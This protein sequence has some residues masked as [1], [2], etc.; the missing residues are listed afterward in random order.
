MGVVHRAH[1]QVLHREVA[2][3]QL[4][5]AK[6]APDR[7]SLL[8]ALF[9][10]EYHTL[11]R[12]KHPR[13]IEVYDYG[14]DRDGPYYTM[15]LLS[16]RDLQRLAPLPYRE[17][18]QL[19]CDVA[20]SLALLHA[21]GL[22]HRDVSP[23]NVRRT[24]DG[25]TKLFDFGALA[26]F[27]VASNIVGT[28]TCV[29]PEMLQ[30]MPLDQRA[31]L[32]SLGVVGYVALTGRPPFP[33]ARIEDL[34]GLWEQAPLPPSKYDPS[35]PAALDALIASLLSIDALA[36]PSSAAAA[37]EALTVIGEIAH[38][39]HE[40]AA[41]SYLL[42]GRLVGRASEQ[43]WFGKRIMRAKS[44]TGSQILMTGAAGLGK[45]RLLHELALEAQLAGLSTVKADGQATPEP[46]GVA[47]R[48]SL[49]LLM[50]CSDSAGRAAQPHA[51]L[52]GQLSEAL[53]ERLGGAAPVSLAS[54]PSE[55]RSRLLAALYEWFVAVSREQPLLVAVDN[56]DAVDP[57]S[58]AFLAALGHA[59][60]EAP[61]LL[62]TTQRAADEATGPDAL[63]A[64]RK[65]ANRLKLGA[66]TL[67]DCEQ[68]VRSLFGDV[69]NVGRVAGL[70]YER[71]AGNPRE[72]LELAGFLVRKRIAKYVGGS[73]VLPQ[74]VAGDELPSRIEDVVVA[75]LRA[76]TGAARDLAETL[77]VDGTPVSIER[78]ETIAKGLSAAEVYQALAELVA[79]QILTVDGERYRFRHDG[80]RKGV[81]A[82]LDESRRRQLHVNLAQDLLARSTLFSAQVQAAWHLVRGGEES[83]GAELIVRAGAN[84]LTDEGSYGSTSEVVAALCMALEIYER[85]GR[86]KHEIADVLFPLVPLGFFVDWH[87]VRDH[88]E[89]ALDLGLE[90]SGLARAE[91]LARILGPKLGLAL[92]LGWAAL[93]LRSL[94][95]ARVSYD[96]KSAIRRLC[97]VMPAAIGAASICF[98]GAAIARIQERLTPL[99]LLGKPD[100]IPNLLHRF[101]AIQALVHQDHMQLAVDALS[102]L[103]PHFR[104]A[105]IIASIGDGQSRGMYGGVLYTLALVHCFQ[106][107]GRALELAA[108]MQALRISVWEASGEQIRLF[109]HANRGESVAVA[110]CRERVELFAMRGEST[111]QAD[112]FF[113]ALLMDSD[114]LAADTVA[115][116]R[117]A[118]QL[119]RRAEQIPTLAPY[120]QL[121]QAGYLSLRGDLSKAIDSFEQVLPQFEPHKRLSWL[122]MRAYYA[123]AL[124][125]NGQH[126]HAKQLLTEAL[127]LLDPRDERFA[128][129]RLEAERQL[130]FADAGLGDHASAAQRLDRLLA[131]WGHEDNPLFIGLL[132]KARAEIAAAMSDEPALARHYAQLERCFRPTHNPALIAQ[133]DQLAAQVTGMKT[134]SALASLAVTQTQLELSMAEL[135]NASDRYMHALRLVLQRAHASSGF[136][137]LLQGERLWLAAASST[138]EPPLGLET[139]LRHTTEQLRKP[140][141][142]RTDEDVDDA[143]TALVELGAHALPANDYS[144]VLLTTRSHE[145]PIIVGGLI[146]EQPQRGSL[147]PT[148]LDAIALA[149]HDRPA[150]VTA[151]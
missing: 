88:G 117:N 8:E 66:L 124:N 107:G 72:C 149:L 57:N 71:G 99:K 134:R 59:S 70:V 110:R 17:V 143:A 44:G 148:F 105:D 62:L 104:R 119:A 61:I 56:L 22:V 92:G 40:L 48:L 27:G 129:K 100:Q 130:A 38:D 86:S 18:C 60:S 93:R 24:A 118:E 19:L 126:A 81:L 74:E 33:A 9:S 77:S 131:R 13:I 30:R 55:R 2:L 36:R 80:L 128:V 141:R 116:R 140:A 123:A 85:Q 98:D 75:S 28:P 43:A 96:L 39:T 1:D 41:E 91:R 103:A 63:R 51:A 50:V 113:P 20:S 34:P 94:R 108:E 101:A 58:A 146:L 144:I 67:E 114:L 102:E 21:H 78:C 4:T 12:L 6:L 151:F 89:R 7:R 106:F 139:A 10:R 112:I 135:T 23:R 87:V 65:H 95:A 25:R 37:I 147:D 79:E 3:K 136:L 68:L 90:I 125:R 111:W 47:V 35:I 145:R 109:Y 26:P 69:P 83:R 150:Q 32:F 84:Y 54:D 46:F 14:Q 122:P 11:V 64:L 49:E 82:Q 45:T 121:A 42:S 138:S 15:E 132:H 53:R 73:W 120:A 137:Y 5:A 127:A 31:D 97:G 29:A 115:A 16:G 76:L 142:K 133:L 52:L